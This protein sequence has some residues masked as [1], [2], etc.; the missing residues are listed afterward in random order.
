M[1]KRHKG[2]SSDELISLVR[3]GKI[4]PQQ[5]EAEAAMRGW[6]PFERKPQLGAFDPMRESRW[7]IVMA[8]AWIAWRDLEQTRQQTAAFRSE[9]THWIFREWDQPIKSGTV[10]ARRA[11]WF[12]ETWSEPTTMRLALLE[13]I[14][15]AKG[16]LPLTRLMSVADAEEELWRALSEGR[17]VAEARDANGGPVDIPEREWTYLKLFEERKRDV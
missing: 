5:A 16:K 10:F 11:G 6:P 3:R 12:L 14:L 8:I 4:T 7:S 15:E 2:D 17:L 13:K 1:T 9:S